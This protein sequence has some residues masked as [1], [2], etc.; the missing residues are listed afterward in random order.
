MILAVVLFLFKFYILRILAL[1]QCYKIKF[2]KINIYALKRK[3]ETLKT[4]SSGTR[5]SRCI[6]PYFFD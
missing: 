6:S 1:M 2:P 3:G 4:S 5:R